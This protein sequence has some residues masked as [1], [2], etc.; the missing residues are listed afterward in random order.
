MRSEGTSNTSGQREHG[1]NKHGQ[2]TPASIT[3]EDSTEHRYV[4]SARSTRGVG[5]HSLKYALVLA[6]PNNPTALSRKLVEKSSVD[7]DGGTFRSR[8]QRNARPMPAVAL[9]GLHSTRSTNNAH[10]LV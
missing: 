5:D 6:V 7:S 3:H 2:P 9:C 8:L 1:S 10:R 4:S